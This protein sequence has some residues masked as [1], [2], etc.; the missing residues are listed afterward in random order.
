M[1]ALQHAGV[2]AVGRR[3]A[4][5]AR[6]VALGDLDAGLAETDMLAPV[7]L[8]QARHDQADADERKHRGDGDQKQL[9]G[10][11]YLAHELPPRPQHEQPGDTEDR[12][13]EARRRQVDV[14]GKPF[15]GNLRPPRDPRARHPAVCRRPAAC[16]HRRDG[17]PRTL[18]WDPAAP[19]VRP[20]G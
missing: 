14:E 17:H 19:I 18:P 8:H 10:P 3:P 2:L 1:L 16:R 13:T 7:H 4:P 20:A 9:L 5:R 6:Q 11:E 12:R 15:G